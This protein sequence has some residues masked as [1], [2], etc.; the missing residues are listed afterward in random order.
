MSPASTARRSISAGSLR[1]AAMN[2]GLASPGL[3][4]LDD[5]RSA[6]WVAADDDDPHAVLG[7]A[8]GDRLTKAGGGAGH[9]GD[10]RSGRGIGHGGPP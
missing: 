9:Q 7:E 2:A 10:R 6:G 8:Q 4:L 3:D 5:R 1:S